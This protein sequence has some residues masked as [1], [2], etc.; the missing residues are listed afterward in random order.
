MVNAENYRL[1]GQFQFQDISLENKIIERVM[2]DLKPL[3][4]IM[5]SNLDTAKALHARA[6]KAG[7]HCTPLYLTPWDDWSFDCVK[8]DKKLN[9]LFDLHS[10]ASDY[11]L[12]GLDSVARSI[13]RKAGERK[14]LLDYFN[15]AWDGDHKKETEFWETGLVLGYPICETMAQYYG[16]KTLKPIK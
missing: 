3:G 8:C 4:N 15:L 9:T 1:N 5:A 14:T 10:L 11:R 2:G 7:M 6:T 12:H 13:E 16:V